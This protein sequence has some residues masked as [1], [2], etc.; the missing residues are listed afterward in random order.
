MR[1]C[2]YSEAQAVRS[3]I[4]LLTDNSYDDSN[5]NGDDHYNNSVRITVNATL[6]LL[7]NRYG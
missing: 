5:S 6:L 3:R 7:I 2:I 4:G 1:V